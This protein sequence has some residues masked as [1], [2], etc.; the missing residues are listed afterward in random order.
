MHYESKEG[1]R[2]TGRQYV[3]WHVCDFRT[4]RSGR[5]R[6]FHSRVVV[7]QGYI[8]ILR[9]LDIYLDILMYTNFVV[10]IG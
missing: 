7:L 1:F 6:C 10:R 3:A 4:G 9:Y 8:F 5:G 2:K